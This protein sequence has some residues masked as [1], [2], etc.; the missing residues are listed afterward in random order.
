VASARALIGE[1]RAS[2][3]GRWLALIAL[4][5]VWLPG[6]LSLPA[7][8]AAGPVDPVAALQA[9]C[10]SP[11]PSDG[12]DRRSPGAHDHQGCSCCLRCAAVGMP[13]SGPP[14]ELAGSAFS[15]VVSDPAA[16]WPGRLPAS[17]APAVYL[18]R[19]PPLIG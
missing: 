17:A 13:G 6:P 14:P 18:S 4:L 10:G 3:L 15:G 2:G 1:L 8:A 7:G 19:A 11:P 16:F 12:S 9:F 5:A